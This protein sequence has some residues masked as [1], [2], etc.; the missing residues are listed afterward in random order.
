MSM[1]RFFKILGIAA[2]LTIIFGGI[3]DAQ[4]ADFVYFDPCEGS[5]TQF[6]ST[7]T[8]PQGITSYRWNFNDG[9]AY[10]FGQEVY[11][12]Y[13]SN[14][15]YYVTLD[16]Y[17]SNLPGDSLVDSKSKNVAIYALPEPSFTFEHVC[18][19]DSVVFVNNTMNSDGEIVSWEWN[20]GD[21]E[22]ELI[23]SPAHFYPV[24]GTYPV[25]LSVESSYGCQDTY[26]DTVQVYQLPDATI[27]YENTEVCHGEKIELWVNDSYQQVIWSSSPQITDPNVEA[28]HVWLSPPDGTYSYAAT[29]Y[30]VHYE[31]GVVCK[32]TSEISVTVHPTPLIE[33]TS[34]EESVIP[35][36]EVTLNVTSSNTTLAEFWWTPITGISNPAAQSP[37][38]NVEETTIFM[39]DVVDEFGC[40]ANGSIKVDVDLKPNNLITPNADGKNDYW[41]VA[42]GGLSD[43]FELVIYN[44]WGEEVVSQKGYANDWDGTTSNGD[45]L[46]EGAYYYVIKHL[47]VT[48]T[49][50]VTL[51]R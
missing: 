15:V 50:A 19:G 20:F 36:G 1:K 48:Y 7:S 30:E 39:V 9:S 41:I 25:S 21:G 13:V 3:A 44:R 51:L 45:K 24:P 31:T 11:H 14:G 46:P 32:S 38:T 18:D 43:E 17:N 2:A 6:V 12:T 40:K 5:Q 37:T 27:S 4:V 49:G 8:Y 22:G 16:V 23:E 33:L 10:A 29:V 28:F 34:S 42:K 35:G 26:F 47:D